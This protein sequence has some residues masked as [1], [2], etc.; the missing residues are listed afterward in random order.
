L[1]AGYHHMPDFN[2]DCGA[3]ERCVADTGVPHRADP[4][5]WPRGRGPGCGW[6]VRVS[7]I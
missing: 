4:R 1:T 3:F 6:L 7:A 2:S 5:D